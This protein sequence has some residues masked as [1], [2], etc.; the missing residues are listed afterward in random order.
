MQRGKNM[1][2]TLEFIYTIILLL[3]IFLIKI[4]SGSTFRECVSDKDCPIM[5]RC[6]IRC[7]KGLCIPVGKTF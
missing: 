7:R 2:K 5:P 6:N 4:V 3:S 1:T